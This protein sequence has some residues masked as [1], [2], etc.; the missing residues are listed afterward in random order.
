MTKKR[1]IIID[2]DRKRLNK[3]RGGRGVCARGRCNNPWM[4]RARVNGNEESGGWRDSS[5]C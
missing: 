1:I 5:E 4:L 2:D 3:R